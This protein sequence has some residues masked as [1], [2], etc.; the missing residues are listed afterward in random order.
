MTHD[1][2]FIKTVFGLKMKQY[3][4]KKIARSR[5]FQILQDSP[6]RILTRL[7]T[8]KSTQNMIKLPNLQRH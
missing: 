7:K 2:E 6:N 8:A 3:R 5:I 1:G 4:Q